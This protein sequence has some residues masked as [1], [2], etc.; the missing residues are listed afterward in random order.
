MDKIT[1]P[2]TIQHEGRTLTIYDDDPLIVNGK[3]FFTYYA[4]DDVSGLWEWCYETKS[5]IKTCA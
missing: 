5:V 2:E 1:P 4:G 3:T